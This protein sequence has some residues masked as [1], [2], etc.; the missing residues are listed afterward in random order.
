MRQNLKPRLLAHMHDMLTEKE[1]DLQAL[2]E[3]LQASEEL[4]GEPLM[5]LERLENHFGIASSTDRKVQPIPLADRLDVLEQ[6]AKECKISGR[7]RNGADM[8]VERRLAALEDAARS[9]E[10]GAGDETVHQLRASQRLVEQL[11]EQLRVSNAGRAELVGES[12]RWQYEAEAYRTEAAALRKEAQALR[13][14][15]RSAAMRAEADLEA[16]SASREVEGLRGRLAESMREASL[17]RTKIAAREAD[18]A[19][20]ELRVAELDSA[21]L[22]SNGCQP[23]SFGGNAKG[24]F[25]RPR[26]QAEGL[27]GS[28][29][30]DVSAHWSTEDVHGSASHHANSS[31]SVNRHASPL[32][33][34][35]QAVLNQSVGSSLTLDPE[36]HSNASSRREPQRMI[37]APASTSWGFHFAPAPATPHEVAASIKEPRAALHT[38]L[39][40]SSSPMRVMNATGT[41]A[42]TS[43]PEWPVRTSDIS[44]GLLTRP[45]RSP[46]SSAFSPDP[47]GNAAQTMTVGLEGLP[48]FPQRPQSP[49]RS[50]SVPVHLRHGGGQVHTVGGPGVS[51]ARWAAAPAEGRVSRRSIG[52]Q[53]SQ[54]MAAQPMVGQ[55]S[56]LMTHLVRC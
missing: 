34:Q 49:V 8:D 12:Q 54:A 1:E 24:A 16:T 46:G 31:R 3:R 23:A 55:A 41:T 17:L 36:A 11:R 44:S 19:R 39:S 28:H 40:R 43:S 4:Q 37:S 30:Q 52:G 50:Q 10:A 29:S 14:S 33:L 32:S 21:A 15:S 53:P 6:R 22:A 38:N 25:L 9:W 27:H 13:S 42:A 45:L 47:P 26:L 48:V 56:P 35:H 7:A 2:Q 18:V 5:R 20:L 51:L